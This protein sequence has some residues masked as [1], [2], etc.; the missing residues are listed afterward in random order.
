MKGAETT[1][2]VRLASSDVIG[3]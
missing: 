2:L 1:G 3:S